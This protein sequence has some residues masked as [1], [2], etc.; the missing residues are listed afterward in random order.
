SLRKLL[1]KEGYEATIVSDGVEALEK[2]KTEEFDL[3][4]LDIRMPLLDGIETIKNAREI[5]GQQGKTLIPEILI[6]GYADEEKYK[7]AVDLKV[8]GF[9]YKPFDTQELLAIIKNTLEK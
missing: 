4:I 1:K 6:T 5:R 8:S 3:L 2:I 9:L 7:N